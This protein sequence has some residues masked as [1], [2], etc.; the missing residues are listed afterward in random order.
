MNELAIAVAEGEVLTAADRVTVLAFP[1]PFESRRLM[2]TFPAGASVAEILEDARDELELP[3]ALW[4]LIDGEFVPTAMLARVRPKAGAVVTVRAAL[5][6]GGSVLRSVLGLAIAVAALVVA[7]YLVGALGI[8]AAAGFSA[9]FISGATALVGGVIAVGGMLALNA[10]FPVRPAQLASNA[11]AGGAFTQLAS[12][13]GARNQAQPYEAIPVVLGTHRMSPAYAAKPYTELLGDDQYLRLLFCWGYGPLSIDASSLKIGETPLSS[14]TDYEIE[15]IGG[16]VGDPALTLYPS[17]VD[18]QSLAVELTSTAGDGETLIDGD[19]TW[20][21]RTTAPDCDRISIDIT[22]P[23]GVSALDTTTGNFSAYTSAARA[24]YRVS[25]SGGAWTDLVRDLGGTIRAL[26]TKRLGAAVD[27]ARGQ[28]EVRVGKATKTASDTATR[29]DK[30][31]WSA[32]RS[33]TNDAPVAFPQR[34][35]LTAL[36]IK[37][38]AQLNGVLDTFNGVISAKVTAYNGSSW[39]ANTVSSNPADLFRHVLQH[40]ANAQDLGR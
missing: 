37:A 18:E 35:A 1:R 10:L 24:Q 32:L 36:R 17:Q 27:V 19:V 2:R 25:G 28:Y 9:G 8:T 33:F 40:A 23:E 29:K 4:V 3:E 39:V 15:T 38:T 16:E 34:L 13:Q 7:P 11:A 5:H 22:Y 26:Q 20:F 30:I 6:G 14:F 31:V 12:I 21:S